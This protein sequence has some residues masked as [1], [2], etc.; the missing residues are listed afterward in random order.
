MKTPFRYRVPEEVAQRVRGLHPQIKGKIR[1]GLDLLCRER[2]AGKALHA[3]FEG[4]RSLRTGRYRII[5]RVA[6]RRV[7]E[8][9]AVGPRETIYAETL[10]LLEKHGG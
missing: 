1:A 6:P 7:L 4:L 2:H 3:E 9:I 8:I 5:Y 10:R